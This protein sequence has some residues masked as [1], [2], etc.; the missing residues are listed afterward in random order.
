MINEIAVIM[1]AKV[2]M[3]QPASNLHTYPL[4]SDAIRLVAVAYVNSL[5]H[6]VPT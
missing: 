3:R 4:Q 2:G 6:G 1:N 5:S